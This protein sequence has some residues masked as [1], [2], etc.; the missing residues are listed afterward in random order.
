MYVMNVEFL[1]ASL[2]SPSSAVPC[3]ISPRGSRMWLNEKF[4]H[5]S[6]T[7]AK[8][9]LLLDEIVASRN[10]FCTS[11]G[12]GMTVEDVLQVTGSMDEVP[13]LERCDGCTPWGNKIVL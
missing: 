11:G 5:A 3:N 6:S 13:R 12:A 7:P 8:L 1:N 9:V 10:G 2:R 4:T